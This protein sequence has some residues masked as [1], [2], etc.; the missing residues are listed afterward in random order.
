MY[1]LI[2]RKTILVLGVGNTLLKDEGIGVHVIER[3]QAMSLLDEEVELLDGGVLG[4]DLIEPMEDREKVIIIDAVQG[5]EVP[6]TIYRLRRKDIEMGKD[7]HLS[8]LHDIDLPYVL[9]MAEL[10]GKHIDPVII[11]VEPEDMSPGLELSPEI[12]A[13]IPEVIDMVFKEI[14]SHRSKG[15]KKEC[16]I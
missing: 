2:D 16:S 7:W 9:N 13:K 11:G 3:M 6:G 15:D 1:N 12:E 14:E 4:L 10:M 8:S 5:G